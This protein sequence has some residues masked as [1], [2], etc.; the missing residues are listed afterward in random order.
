MDNIFTLKEVAKHLKVEYRTVLREIHRGNLVAHHVGN[1]LLISEENLSRYLNKSNIQPLRVSVAVV[2]RRQK[3]LLVKRR[4]KEGV[5]QWQF[6]AGTVQFKERTSTRAEIECLQ[7]TGIH[8]KAQ[9]KLGYRVHPDTKVVI[10]YWACDYIEGQLYNVDT[11]ENSEVKWVG[12]IEPEGL[13]PSDYYKPVKSYL[14]ELHEKSST[15]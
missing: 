1:I 15:E 12:L 13:F 8:C 4:F 3:V 10:S 11:V 9:R 5:L 6:P 14:R 7:E 2:T